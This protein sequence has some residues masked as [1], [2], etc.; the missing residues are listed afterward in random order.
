MDGWR[1]IGLT[2]NSFEDDD[3]NRETYSSHYFAHN[4]FALLGVCLFT[5][6]LKV[7]AP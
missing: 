3:M 7:I 1:G 2:F 4:C 6:T 5:L